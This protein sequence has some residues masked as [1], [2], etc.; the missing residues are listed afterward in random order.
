MHLARIRRNGNTKLKK[1]S[2]ALEKLPHKI[3]DDFIKK[4]CH[5][6]IDEDISNRLKKMG[7]QGATVWTVK[8]RRRKLG[9]KKYL[10]GE[11]KKHKA[12]VRSQAIKKYGHKC[13][14]CNYNLTIDTHHIKPKYTGGKH[15]IDNLMVLC[16]NCHALITRN[17]FNLTSRKDIAKVQR[18]VKRLLLTNRI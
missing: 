13:E 2:H 16:P 14:L 10:Y 15:E 18:E 8:F 11:I 4:N 7:Y 9:V 12:W 3:V 17:I 6:M 1:G 5:D